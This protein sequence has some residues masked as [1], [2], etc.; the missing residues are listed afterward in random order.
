MSRSIT[1]R[2]GLQRADDRGA[3]R[4]SGLGLDVEAAA[5]YRPGLAVSA[6]LEADDPPADG[7]DEEPPV[8]DGV[9]EG[10][11]VDPQ[12]A[13][14]FSLAAQNWG[15]V[16]AGLIATEDAEV[17]YLMGGDGV[18]LTVVEGR[19][20]R[21]LVK[22]SMPTG[23]FLGQLLTTSGNYA[24]NISALTTSF[25]SR[26]QLNVTEASYTAGGAA[27][28]IFGG[29]AAQTITTSQYSDIVHGGGGNDFIQTGAGA[30]I[31]WGGLGNDQAAGSDGADQLWGGAGNDL[32]DGGGEG[33][34]MVGGSGLDTLLGGSGN[35]AAIGGSGADSIEGGE[36]DDRLL[37]GGGADTLVGGEGADT[38]VFTE[39]DTSS[40]AADRLDRV[41]DFVIGE[42][43]I[44]LTGFVDDLTIVDEFTN[45]K[46]QVT[47]ED[48]GS[49]TVVRI[50]VNGDGTAELEI[51]VVTADGEMLTADDFV[52]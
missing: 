8:D 16:Y 42:D 36:G 43:K 44:D 28:D 29:T 32:L 11:A 20:V 6:G 10:P 41:N 26:T 35:D 18:G 30:D 23:D 4:Q 45:E 7:E 21:Y 34:F 40:A 51:T 17:A 50:D 38:F 46:S 9:S 49:E 12:S 47:L 24:P 52:L 14:L 13:A 1:A 39:L 22:S 5:F 27:V 37:G 19:G 25:G 2:R 33:D 31:V 15:A 48:T 3:A